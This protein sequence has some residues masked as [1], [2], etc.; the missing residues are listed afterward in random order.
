MRFVTMVS[1]V[2]LSG[3]IGTSCGAKEFFVGGRCEKD[4]DCHTW[5]QEAEGTICVDEQCVCADADKIVG[6][7]PGEDPCRPACVLAK[8]NGTCMER[9]PSEWSVPLL[10]WTGDADLA[11][12]CPVLAPVTRFQ[13]IVDVD[14]SPASCGCDCEPAATTCTIPTDWVAGSAPCV[15][16]QAGGV[17]TPFSAPAGWDGSCTAANP[18]SGGVQSLGIPPVTLNAAPCTAKTTVTPPQP[19][20]SAIAL[21]CEP[22]TTGWC[23]STTDE[24]CVVEHDVAAGWQACVMSEGDRECP[25]GY[26]T[27]LMAYDRVEDTRGCEPC[28]CGAPT[29][30]SC[31]IHVEV[32]SNNTC[33]PPVYQTF[34][35]SSSAAC[36]SA[37]PDI[38]LGSKSAMVLD[39]QPATCAPVGGA[40]SGGVLTIGPTTFCCAD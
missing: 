15:N 12:E 40:P 35:D 29:G 32:A 23:G 36:L 39:L 34:V 19:A 4:A 30:G 16:N 1:I 24:L 27:R 14:T 33:S 20:G 18:V 38:G 11:P 22:A 2:A 3:G 10:V 31:M 13:G 28:T 25:E 6:C 5:S 26:P 7:A 9:A 21:A 17:L 8:C 37:L